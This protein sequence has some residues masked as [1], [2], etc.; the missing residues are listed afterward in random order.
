MAPSRKGLEMTPNG[1]LVKRNLQI[2]L[3]Q[4][5]SGIFEPHESSDISICRL[6]T[7]LRKGP[8]NICCQGN[9]VSSES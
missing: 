9:L 2:I 7:Y 8:F 3:G 1:T 4:W 5:L 6:E